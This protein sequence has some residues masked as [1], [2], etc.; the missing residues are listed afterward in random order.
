MK[1]Q[2]AQIYFP[3]AT[4]LEI[5]SIATAYGK[6]FA[7]WARDVLVKEAQKE[8]RKKTS[9][10]DIKFFDK[11]T[12]DPHLSEHINDVLYGDS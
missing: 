4:Y 10:A 5:K 8:N 6:P 9:L 1:Q 12:N 11:S 3:L 7:T 2:A